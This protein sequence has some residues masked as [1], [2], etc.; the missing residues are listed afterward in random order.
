[1]RLFCTVLSLWRV[2]LSARNDWG[3]SPGSQKSSL[4]HLPFPNQCSSW[5]DPCGSYDGKTLF[6]NNHQETLKR[7]II[8]YLQ[9]L[10]NR[11]T[12]GATQ[13]MVE[14]KREHVGQELLY[15][16]QGQRPRVSRLTLYCG[17]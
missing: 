4:R 6:S 13:I 11:H 8:Y 15:L 17:L 1:M 3:Q 14:K 12:A 2:M 5:T 16:G 9:D 7:F 10:E